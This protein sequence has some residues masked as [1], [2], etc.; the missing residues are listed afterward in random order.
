[1]SGFDAKFKMQIAAMI[2][3]LSGVILIVVGIAIEI[4][5]RGE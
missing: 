5:S 3:T 1:M 2:M 4:L